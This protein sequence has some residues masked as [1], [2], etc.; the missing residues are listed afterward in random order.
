MIIRYSKS[1]IK[2]YKTRIKNNPKLKERF[3]E[4][5]KIFVRNPDSPVLKDHA[6]I[7]KMRTFRSFSVA[8]DLR[9]IYFLERED[10]A[11]FIDVGTHNQ[12]YK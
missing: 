8:G 5:L 10:L 11:I 12:V 7:G 3:E 6:L 9:V 4:R 2:S 1:F